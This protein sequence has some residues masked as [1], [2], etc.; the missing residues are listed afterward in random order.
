[1]QNI[2][3]SIVSTPKHR[4][5]PV[6]LRPLQHIF[7]M[8]LVVPGIM[9]N[10]NGD[11]TQDWTNKLVGKTLCEGPSSEIVSQLGDALVALADDPTSPGLLQDGAAT[12]DASHRAR[13]DGDQGLQPREAQRPCQRGWNRLACVP[14]LGERGAGCGTV[15]RISIRPINNLCYLNFADLSRLPAHLNSL[16]RE[17]TSPVIATNR[18]LPV[19]PAPLVDD[20]FHVCLARGRGRLR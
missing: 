12:E 17:H 20:G 15:V 14:W 19:L 4:F 16:P 2:C 10:N 7:K 1:M 9:N 5:Q 3:K 8:P 11:K 13:L 18:Y 6:I